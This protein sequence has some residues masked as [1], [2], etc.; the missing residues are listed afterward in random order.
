MSEES[1]INE[2]AEK[3][4]NGI[5][6][7]LGKKWNSFTDEQRDSALRAAKRV[8]QLEIKKMQGKD[9]AI[10]LRFV[11][12][13]MGEFELAAKIAFA[14][15]FWEEMNKALEAFG[16]FLAGVGKGLIPGL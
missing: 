15:I 3:G 1:L 6:E 7:R 9:V 8:I 10:E 5:K 2:Y 13:T 16:S 14:D 12:V 11:K 4:L